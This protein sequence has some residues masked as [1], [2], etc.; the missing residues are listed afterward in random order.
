MSLRYVSCLE[1]SISLRILNLHT[2]F[3]QVP[4]FNEQENTQAISSDIAEL[5]KEWITEALRPSSSL[6]R[7]D[8]PVDMVDRAVSKYLEELGAQRVETRGAF[9]EVRRQLRRYW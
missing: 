8:F 1:S 4:P 5:L 7:G 2:I 3:L 6:S 9:E